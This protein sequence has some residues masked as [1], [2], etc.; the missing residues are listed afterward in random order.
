MNTN[1]LA[2][3]YGRLTP[4]ERMSLLAAGRKHAQASGVDYV[5]LMTPLR[6][7]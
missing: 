2:K 1:G 4:S 6:R 5:K 7:S 3:L